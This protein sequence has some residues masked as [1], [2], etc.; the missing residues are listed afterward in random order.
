[1][2]R[3]KNPEGKEAL[4]AAIEK[5]LAEVEKEGSAQD[6]TKHVALTAKGITGDEPFKVSAT[7]SDTML[8][9]RLQIDKEWHMY[10]RDTIWA[11]RETQRAKSSRLFQG[12]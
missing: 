5:L 3:F 8:T 4:D 7:V 1:M 12:R 2:I 9:I 11:I 10:G 6:K